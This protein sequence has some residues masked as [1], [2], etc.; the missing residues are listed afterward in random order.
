VKNTITSIVMTCSTV[1][2]PIL[3]AIATPLHGKS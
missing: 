2:L 1:K 3:R